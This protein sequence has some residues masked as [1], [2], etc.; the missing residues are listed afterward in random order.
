MSK[1]AVWAKLMLAK[2][3]QLRIK[4][5]FSDEF[6]IPARK[7]LKRMHISVYHSRRPMKGLVPTQE[8]INLELSVAETRFMV[9][10]PGGENPRSDINPAN[11]AIGIRLHKQS[12][13][14]ESVREFRSRLLEY[15]SNQVLGKRNPSTHNRSA[16]GARNF[17]PHMSLL[18]PGSVLDDNIKEIAAE[19]R[20]E[21]ETLKFD[22]FVTDI[23][24]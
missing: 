14:I 10:Y 17:Q 22:R 12:N 19:F 24:R 20:K 21:F 9:M 2:E 18:K 8:S 13:S 1:V 4:H 16:F 7:V 23:D 11:H 6:G 5:F 3:D 15:E